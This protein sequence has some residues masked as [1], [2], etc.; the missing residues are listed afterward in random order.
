MKLVSLIHICTSF[1]IDSS[2]KRSIGDVYYNHYSNTGIIGEA[3]EF[4]Y[5]L[6]LER[7][8]HRCN[9]IGTSLLTFI[10]DNLCLTA[11]MCINRYSDFLILLKD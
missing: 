6:T 5:Q 1:R 10:N 8:Q 3:S 2:S 11:Y 9:S 7:A 4:D